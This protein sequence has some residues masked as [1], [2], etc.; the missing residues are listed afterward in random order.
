MAFEKATAVVTGGASGLGRA[1]CEELGRRGARVIVSDVN[2]EGA[3]ETAASVESLGG[4]ARV[5]V[6]D[7]REPGQLESLAKAADEWLGATD[8]LVNNAGVAVSG[9][10]GDVTL[11]DWKWQI[12]INLWGVIYGCHFWTPRMK[13]RGHGHI[14][15]VASAAGLLALPEMAPYNVA[16]AGVVALSETLHGELKASGIKVT[17]LCPTFFRTNIVESA[18]GPTAGEARDAVHR[19]MDKSK[20]QAPDVARLSLEAV[21]RG[22]LYCV[23]MRDGRVS[24]R[25]KRMAPNGFYGL[26]GRLAGN[27]GLRRLIER[28]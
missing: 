21:H 22:K 19:V 13:A 11:E 15:N 10:M 7:V 12:D 23:P 28:G 17:A 20:I 26:I 9:P 24:W 14:I 16:K 18:R 4:Q 6:C 1:F 8:L 25:V 3:D 5:E 2:R 27:D